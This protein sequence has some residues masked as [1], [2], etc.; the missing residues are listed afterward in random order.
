MT[1]TNHLPLSYGRETWA[2]GCPKGIRYLVE[3]GC[4]LSFVAAFWAANVFIR[5]YSVAILH[6][7]TASATV[8]FYLPHVLEK[9]F[10]HAGCL[11]GL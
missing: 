10:R 6:V 4:G 1:P 2:T 9:V 8:G 11:V 5:S 7:S 3:V